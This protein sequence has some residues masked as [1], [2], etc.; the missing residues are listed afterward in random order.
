M[1]KIAES[2]IHAMRGTEEQNYQEI[3]SGNHILKDEIREHLILGYHDT[4]LSNH[5]PPPPPPPWLGSTEL[6]NIMMMTA[7]TMYIH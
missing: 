2:V 1:I 5:L 7:G 3:I 4:D 6:T